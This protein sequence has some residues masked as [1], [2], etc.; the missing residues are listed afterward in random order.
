MKT[1]SEARQAADAATG[2]AARSPFRFTYDLAVAD[3]ALQ[4]EAMV[5]LVG[6]GEKIDGIS[7]LVESVRTEFS[8]TGL[9]Q[10]IEL[11]SA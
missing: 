5:A 8:A 7:W 4:P 11:E 3:L 1:G 10:S 2:R 9:R 6:W